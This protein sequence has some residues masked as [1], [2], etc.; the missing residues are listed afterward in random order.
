MLPP[1]QQQ[2]QPLR[3]ADGL[4]AE[5]VL[6]ISLLLADIYFL[7][8]ELHP[9]HLFQP[10][11]SSQTLPSIFFRVFLVGGFGPPIKQ[12]ML[13]VDTCIDFSTAVCLFV[14]VVVVLNGSRM[15]WRSDS[16]E[17]GSSRTTSRPSS[18]GCCWCQIGW[19]SEG[20]SSNK[21]PSEGADD[22]SPVGQMNDDGCRTV[23]I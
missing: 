15:K 12:S 5:L 16:A 7:A 9:L 13:C 2:Q 4:E 18:E 14:V 10:L 6:S 8:R 11:P 20:Q 3:R 17:N 23:E 1:Q 21:E 19:W 22:R